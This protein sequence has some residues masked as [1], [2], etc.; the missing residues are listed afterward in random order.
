MLVSVLSILLS[1]GRSIYEQQVKDRFSLARAP[2][3]T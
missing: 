3:A 1:R 2:R